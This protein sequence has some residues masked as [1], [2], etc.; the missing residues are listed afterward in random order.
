MTLKLSACLQ[1]RRPNPV[2]EPDTP[3]CTDLLDRIGQLSV[4]DLHVL[5][6]NPAS[7][8]AGITIELLGTSIIWQCFQGRVIHQTANQNLVL[9]DA[10]RSLERSALLTA[11][12]YLRPGQM[13]EL[14]RQFNQNTA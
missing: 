5:P 7:G 9:H 14:I 4:M 6:P 8:Y 10:Q 2:W 13:S 12:P 1:T 3:V 11:R